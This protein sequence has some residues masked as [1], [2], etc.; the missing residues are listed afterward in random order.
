MA[1]VPSLAELVGWDVDS[2][3]QA[4]RFWECATRISFHNARALE[5]GTGNGGLSLW[6]ARKGFRVTC[7]D[8]Q[9]P[10]DS[11]K[12][13]HARYGVNEGIEYRS[14]DATAIPFQA[15][16]D[17]LCFKS[18]LGA[19]GS[20][21]R[22]ERQQ[23][24]VDEMHA[25]LKRGGEVWFAEN[26]VSSA[27]HR[28]CRARF[29]PWGPTWRWISIAEVE[30]FFRGFSQ[31]QYVTIGFAAVFGRTEWQR[32]VLARIDSRIVRYVPAEW[33]YIVAGIARR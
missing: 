20:G 26:L 17:L 32:G 6:L 8:I 7:S 25:A 11:V 14:V 30:E 22:K 1:S 28:Y 33:R 21:G 13:L 16:L 29:V 15:E 12:E 24:A 3:S 2:W 4:L 5:L 18:M 23:Q 31:L 27:V 19:V 9:G 10:K